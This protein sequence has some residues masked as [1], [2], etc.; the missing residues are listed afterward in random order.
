MHGEQAAMFKAQAMQ[1]TPL[2]LI[3]WLFLSL[4]LIRI[5][6]KGALAGANKATVDALR[7]LQVR[8]QIAN[9]RDKATRYLKELSTLYSD[10]QTTFRE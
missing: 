4:N 8:A 10:I 9:Q 5:I 2:C 7:D 1:I 6:K 3:S